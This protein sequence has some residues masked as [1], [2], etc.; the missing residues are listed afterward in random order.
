MIKRLVKMIIPDSVLKKITEYKASRRLK[1]ANKYDFEIYFE[2]SDLKKRDTAN[3][4]IGLII[5]EYHAI[6]KGLIMPEFRLGFGKDR[7]ISLCKNC[8]IY[9]DQFGIDDE[10]LKHAIGVIFEYQH[11]HKINNYNIDDEI[12]DAIKIVKDKVNDIEI[13]CQRVI[14]KEEF[15]AKSE[16]NFYNFSNSRSSVRNY[17]NEEISLSLIQDSLD[18][19]RNTPS[20]CNRQSVR[21]YVYTNKKLINQILEIQGGNRGFG[22]LANK[23]VIVTADHSL[24]TGIGERN[25]A[26][27]DG[28]M[29]AMNLLYALHAHK[30]AACILNCSNTPEK[31]VLLRRICGIKKTEVFIAMISCG[32]PPDNFLIASSKRYPINKTNTIIE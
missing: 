25:Q 28:G 18:L 30:I 7:I 32:I 8:C 6:E 17:T 23:L 21:T 16:T 13:S 3:N 5:R 9:I 4:W 22:H 2:A 15:F 29:Y 20:A 11:V 1:E 12:A 19:A 10:Q 31:D 26:F 27:I 24:Y 14:S